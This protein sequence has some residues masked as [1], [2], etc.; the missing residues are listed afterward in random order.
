MWQTG[1]VKISLTLDRIDTHALLPSV[2]PLFTNR[3]RP[4][5]SRCHHQYQKL[6]FLKRFGNLQPP[7]LAPFQ[8]NSVLPE[9]DML[10]FQPM[11]QL[12][13]NWLTVC[14][15]I[16]DEDTRRNCGARSYTTVFSHTIT[17]RKVSRTPS[18]QYIR[19]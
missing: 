3:L 11:P 13:S 19:S 16:G 6:D 7:I 12:R 9:W 14:A 10:S 17:L 2:T 8:A 5:G 15:R 4:H 1:K 18:V